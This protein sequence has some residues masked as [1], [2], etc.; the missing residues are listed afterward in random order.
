MAWLNAK[1]DLKRNFSKAINIAKAE[2][3]KLTQTDLQ[4]MAIETTHEESLQVIV[5]EAAYRNAL[6]DRDELRDGL[7][8]LSGVSSNRRASGFSQQKH[9]I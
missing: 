3:D 9:Q 1:A 6:A 5:K 8:S 7:S 4:A 2:N